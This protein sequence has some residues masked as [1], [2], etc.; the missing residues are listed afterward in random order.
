MTGCEAAAGSHGWL[1]EGD[2]QQGVSML[3]VISG[4]VFCELSNLYLAMLNQ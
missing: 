4:G 2:Q 1:A 3:H